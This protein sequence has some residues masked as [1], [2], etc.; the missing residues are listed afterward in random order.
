MSA[1]RQWFVAFAIVF[2]GYVVITKKKIFSSIGVV[3]VA[4][5]LL[6]VLLHFDL[7]QS[8]IQLQSAWLRIQQIFDVARGDVYAVDTAENRLVNQL[9]IILGVIKHNPIIGYGFS[10]ITMRF[11]DND[12]G[13]VNTVLMFGLVGL[14]FF[15]YFFVKMFALLFSCGR[16]MRASSTFKQ[17]VYTILIAWSSILVIYFSTQDFFSFYFHKVFFVSIMIALTEFFVV[18]AKNEQSP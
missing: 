3:A 4:L 1:T 14:A 16:K 2:L 13:F 8:N 18:Q 11:Y 17:P 10:Y 15:I 7:F 9:P 5:V 6:G 12:L